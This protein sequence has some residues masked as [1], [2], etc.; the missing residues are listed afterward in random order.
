MNITFYIKGGRIFKL[1]SPDPIRIGHKNIQNR[2]G[3][4]VFAKIRA[5]TALDPKKYFCILNF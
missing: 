1:K 2:F 4:K 3:I 5:G